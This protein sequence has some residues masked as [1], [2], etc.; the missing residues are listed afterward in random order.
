MRVQFI[1]LLGG[2]QWPLFRDDFL[3]QCRIQATGFLTRLEYRVDAA[4]LLDAGH[5]TVGTQ[6]AASLETRLPEPAEAGTP[7][8]GENPR[9]SVEFPFKA[10][11]F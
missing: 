4:R 7:N 1:H 8:E 6:P 11:T 2:P 9:N 10:S 5:R 3:S